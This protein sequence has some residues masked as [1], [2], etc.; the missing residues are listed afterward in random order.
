[1]PLQL[2]AVEHVLRRAPL[3]A[4]Y[5]AIDAGLGKTI[6]AAILSNRLNVKCPTRI[7][8]ITPPGLRPNV[9]SE[10]HKWGA[11]KNVYL[12]NSTMLQRDDVRSAVLK[13]MRA[14]R[15]GGGRTCLIV[16]EAHH[17]INEKS[18]R[19]MALFDLADR[20]KRIVFMSA[21]PMPNSRPVEL[22]PIL[23]RFAP[24][25]FGVDFFAYAKKYCGARRVEIGHNWGTGKP[26]LA[27]E[28]KGFTNRPEFRD[29]LF[30]S[31][32][33][34]VRKKD[35]ELGLPAKMESLL[36][37]GPGMSPVVS[38]LERKMLAHFSPED[39]V[40]AQLATAAGKPSLYLAEYLRLLGDH[41]LKYVLPVI[42]G[43][44]SSTTDTLLIFA[45]HKSV[46]ETLSTW[47]NNYQPCVIAGNVPSKKRH[48][49]VEAFKAD[50]KRRLFIGNILAAGIGLNI[51]KGNRV[52]I[53]E[54]SWRDG[55][56]SQAEDRAHRIGQKRT[57]LVQYVVLRDSFERK[58]ME[59]ILNKRHAA[60]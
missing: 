14:W 52:L 39:L 32:M 2:A 21:T 60:V 13:N 47:L 3:R 57:V 6:C 33:Y 48:A 9:E 43:I 20:F 58:R 12:I 41:K 18:L 26:K 29:R 36:T 55:D 24:D 22:W 46:I 34:R 44:L 4:T 28:F 51:T 17:Y 8:Y 15:Q 53:I 1:M 23:K 5:L 38:K 49:L 45:H 19:S 56:N 54:P 59:V 30:K 27:W 35:V 50:P 7:Y 42:E 16:D 37:V 31:F 11:N 10:F 40:E 25:V